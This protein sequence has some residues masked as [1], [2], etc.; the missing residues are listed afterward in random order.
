MKTPEFDRYAASYEELLRDPLR[1]AFGQ[2]PDFFQRRK[3]DL[4]RNY[5]VR[6]GRDTRRLEYLDIGCGKGELLSLLAADFARVAGCDPSAAMLEAVKGFETRLQP[7][8]TRIP[9]GDCQF[10]FVTAVCVLHHVPIQARLD[11]CREMRRV[12]RP[13][14]VCALIE[15]NPLNPAT[16]IIVRRTPVDADAILVRAKD[17][18]S[19][20]RR[21]GFTIDDQMYFLYL[22]ERMHKAFPRLESLLGKLPLGGQYAVFGMI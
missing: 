12:L 4:I 18:C 2:S 14:G 19:L 13:G 8:P 10:D 16:R 7:E 15:H 21:A 1:D 11:L 3:R 22:P 6:R 5:F 17:S 9:F 20:L